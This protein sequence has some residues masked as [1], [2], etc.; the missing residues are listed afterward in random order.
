MRVRLIDGMNC[1]PVGCREKPPGRELTV[2]VLETIEGMWESVR[3]PSASQG[4]GI[5]RLSWITRV[6]IQDDQRL[7]KFSVPTIR[8]RCKTI[9]S[10]PRRTSDKRG[11][12]V[13]G[14]WGLGRLRPPMASPARCPVIVAFGVPA[15]AVRT[16]L[17]LTPVKQRQRTIGASGSS[18]G[19]GE[20]AARGKC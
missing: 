1:T 10:V 14:A 11:T 13:R 18:L 3:G 9:E 19:E 8:R 17:G 20:S 4:V 15:C 2:P 16:L 7:D 12:E 5:A 6:Q